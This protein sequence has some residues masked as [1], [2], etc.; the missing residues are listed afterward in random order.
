MTGGKVQAASKLLAKRH[1]AAL[2]TIAFEM[3]TQFCALPKKERWRLGERTEGEEYPL[4]PAM[5]L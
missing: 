1:A 4:C 2:Q 5:I 3:P